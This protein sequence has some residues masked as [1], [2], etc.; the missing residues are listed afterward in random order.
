M[1][2]FITIAILALIA[3]SFYS[4]GKKKGAGDTKTN[5]VQNVDMVKLI[6]ELAA[7][8]VTGSMNIKISNKGDEN[9]AWAKFKNYFTENTLQV[10]VPYEAKFGV[11]MSNQKMNI[12]TKDSTVTIYL[13]PCKMLSLQLKMD[14]LETM[15]QTGIFINASMSDL[16]NAQKKLY[17]EA[18]IKIENDP[19][20]LK[21]AEDHIEDIFKN[22]YTPLGYKVNCVFNRK[23]V[24]QLK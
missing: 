2:N 19:A 15:T 21:L 12:D 6:A 8:D 17:A 7:L 4:L 5:I 16:V 11:D 9:G 13:P 24:P 22:Y 10:N 3:Y 14:R 18:L 23:A 20:Y 1:K